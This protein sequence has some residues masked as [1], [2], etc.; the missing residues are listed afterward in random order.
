ML[1]GDTDTVTDEPTDKVEDEEFDIEDGSLTPEQREARRLARKPYIDHLQDGVAEADGERVPLFD[2]GDRIVVERRISFLTG[3]PWLDTRVYVVKVIDDETGAIHCTDEEMQH[4]A[5]VS[6]K[7]EF[8]RVKL[9]PKKGPIFARKK[10]EEKPKEEP[11]GEPKKRGRPKG[12]KNRPKEV[13]EAER[14]AKVEDR[15][16]G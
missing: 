3:H 5:C 4:Y 8:Q 16:A 2:V 11:T 15:H 7:S 6:F 14:K 10:K 1:D 9:A 13:I 12:S